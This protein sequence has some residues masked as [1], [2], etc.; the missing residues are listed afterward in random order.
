MIYLSSPHR[1]LKTLI[2]NQTLNFLWFLNSIWSLFV[3]GISRSVKHTSKFDLKVVYIASGYKAP[4]RGE[5]AHHDV[6]DTLNA[7]APSLHADN[8][9][10]SML[11]LH[12]PKN[13]TL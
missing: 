12:V 4:R 8:E 13:A 1:S 11:P 6:G 9:E 7:Y 5:K 2:L 3:L 10:G